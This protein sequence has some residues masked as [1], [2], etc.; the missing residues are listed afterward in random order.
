MTEVHPV[1]DTINMQS[2]QTTILLNS[3]HSQDRRF[4]NSAII[5]E[6]LAGT[7]VSSRAKYI[8]LWYFTNIGGFHLTHGWMINVRFSYPNLWQMLGWVPPL[9]SALWAQRSG[10]QAGSQASRLP[11]KMADRQAGRQATGW[12]FWHRRVLRDYLLIRDQM[13]EAW[14]DDR[15][16]R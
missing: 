11:E 8:Q 3:V 12:E 4:D 5:L 15:S 13:G 16:A 9:S 2:S 1:L 14:R 6:V 10:R 7:V